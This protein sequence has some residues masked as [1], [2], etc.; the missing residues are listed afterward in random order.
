MDYLLDK[1][2]HRISILDARTKSVTLMCGAVAAYGDAVD[3]GSGF[4]L[5]CAKC[6]TEEARRKAK[7]EKDCAEG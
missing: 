2:I 7:W 6:L 4:G 3:A 5:V 1:L